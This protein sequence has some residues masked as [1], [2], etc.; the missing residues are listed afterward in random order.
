MNINMWLIKKN[1]NLYNIYNV[2]KD[3]AMSFGSEL[4]D[5]SKK[6]ILSND[7]Y[8]FDLHEYNDFSNNIYYVDDNRKKYYY[9]RKSTFRF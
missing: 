7:K 3:S 5:G 4:T 2:K 6:M 1:E 9:T 8:R